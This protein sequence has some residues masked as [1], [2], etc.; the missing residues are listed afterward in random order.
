M[1]ASDLIHNL[2]AH[3]PEELA[4]YAGQYVAW[5]NDGTAVVAH[6]A[7]LAELFVEVDRQGLTGY[8][9]EFIPAEDGSLLGGIHE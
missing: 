1:K 9:F 6:A 7:T 4:R 3:G 5:S 2:N 8:T